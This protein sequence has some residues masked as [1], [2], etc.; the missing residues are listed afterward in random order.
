MK[1]QPTWT[2]IEENRAAGVRFFKNIGAGKQF[3]LDAYPGNVYRKLN[4]HPS[5]NVEFVVNRHSS[6]YVGCQLSFGPMQLVNV[7]PE[8]VDTDWEALLLDGSE[9]LETANPEDMLA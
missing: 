3:T 4:D 1:K 8:H 6:A 9:L 7:D 5:F 2:T